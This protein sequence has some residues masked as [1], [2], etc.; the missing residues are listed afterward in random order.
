M[1]HPAFDNYERGIYT[2]EGNY[3]VHDFHLSPFGKYGK[4]LDFSRARKSQLPNVGLLEWYYAQCLMARARGYV[5]P[6]R[7]I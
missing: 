5:V 7:E 1:Y 2:L 6:S 3:L 4:K